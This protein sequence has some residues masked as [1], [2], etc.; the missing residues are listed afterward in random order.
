M[1]HPFSLVANSVN[2][3]RWGVRLR[4]QRSALLRLMG[5]DTMGLR[6][7]FNRPFLCGRELSYIAHANDL[8]Q[9]AGDGYYTDLCNEW[10]TRETGSGQAMLTTSATSALEMAAILTDVGPGDEV[11]M[12]SF[13][14]VSTANAF[15]LRGATPV[16]VDIRPDTLNIDEN[17]I[18][19]AV[20]PRTKVVVPV[21]YAG[22]GCN[23]D[24]IMDIANRRGLWVVEDAAQGISSQYQGAALGTI[25]DFGC[26]SFHETKNVTCG[27]GGALLVKDSKLALRAE[28]IREKG[29]NRS[30]FFRGQV[31]KYTWSDIGSSYL[32][33]E[34]SAAFLW[35]QLQQAQS[36]TQRRLDIW[37]SYFSGLRELEEENLLEL[38]RIPPECG[39]NGHLFHI[40][41]K[42]PSQRSQFLEYMSQKSI[43]CVFHYVPLHTSPMGRRIG[44]PSG[45]LPVT[46]SVSDRLV[47]L[48]VW[49]GVEQYLDEIL[50]AIFD[51]FAAEPHGGAS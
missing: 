48:P 19:S 15:A 34:M 49:L 43:G 21:H 18:E 6:V 12:P 28:V 16:F 45:S 32:P 51:F 17:L 41:L 23:M 39:H 44:R 38:P 50:Q 29:T 3:P 1:T 30:Q 22:V 11:I 46:E 24:Q 7:P 31:D 42:S 9:L 4:P 14:F 10:L 36:I 27:E 33:G 20:T 2:A 25:G 26:Y 5:V 40:K 8:G 47:R 35:A 13:T 37:D